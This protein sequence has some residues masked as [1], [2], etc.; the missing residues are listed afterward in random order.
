MAIAVLAENEPESAALAA[1]ATATL[2][3][4]LAPNDVLLYVDR[5]KKHQELLTESRELFERNEANALVSTTARVTEAICHEVR[6]PLQ[7]VR[8]NVGLLQDSN[9]RERPRLTFEDRKEILKDIDNALNRIDSILT[10]LNGLA[11]GEK[12]PVARV[13]LGE[14]VGD[15]LRSVRG[16][17]SAIEVATQA[18]VHG[19]AARGLLHQVVVNVLNNA[20]DAVRRV[21]EPKVTVRVYVTAGEARI[22]IRDNGVGIPTNLRERI[23]EPFF[24]TKGSDGT[25]LGL[26]IARQA[27]AS[28]GGAL[29]VSG[30][31]PPGA[32]F[33]IRLRRG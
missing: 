11:R 10:S 33:R 25:G 29:T 13:D 24:S 27:V 31:D 3:R 4:P 2:H 28:M 32:C 7:A 14:I 6:N 8:L 9:D 18:D 19:M 1:G 23:F 22:S 15:A 26:A 20:L 30:E 16:D 17:S 5:F 21:K 12:P